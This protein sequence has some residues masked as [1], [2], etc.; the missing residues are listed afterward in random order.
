MSINTMSFAALDYIILTAYFALI[1]GVGLWVS[2]KK[3]G[4]EQ[5]AADYFLA[6]KTFGHDC[7][8]YSIFYHINLIL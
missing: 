4:A 3:P 7:F 2:R 8:Y 6:G 5:N 1:L